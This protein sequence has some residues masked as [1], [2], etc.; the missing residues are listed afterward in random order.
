MK[1]QLE[2]KIR[3]F[4]LEN[5]ANWSEELHARYFD[6]PV[7]KYASADD[8]LFEQYKTIIGS[9]HLTPR[10]FFELEFGS[11]SY[12]GGT[13]I[14]IVL[15]IGEEL[16]KSNRPQTSAPSKAWAL[17]NMES[18]SI[19]Q[20]L[21]DDVTA[22]LSELNYR[23]ICPVKNSGFYKVAGFVSNWSERHIAY[24][25]GQGAF[26]INE[27]LITERGIAVRFVSLITELPLAPDIRTA[28][29]YT[30]YCLFLSKGTC[31]ACMKRCP[32][33]AVSPDGHDKLK[34]WNTAYGEKSRQ[35]AQSYGGDG[36]QVAGCALCQTSVPCEYRI[37]TALNISSIH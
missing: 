34:C 15:P 10:E 18:A 9:G 24:A 25:A 27:G 32:A 8:P 12:R 17:F 20:A 5:R 36:K 14:S 22:Y 2:E 4:I 6:A 3:Q 28:K 30:E 13:V 16:R 29:E 7:I 19:V 37:P 33:N 31:G 23:T 11:G 35:L 26:G 1:T 21:A